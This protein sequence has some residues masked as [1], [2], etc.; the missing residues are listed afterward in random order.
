MGGE[1]GDVV[2]CFLYL[3]LLPK[4]FKTEESTVEAFL[5]VFHSFAHNFQNKPY[6]QSNRDGMSVHLYSHK[7]I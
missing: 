1:T 6:F 5:F 3:Q 7:V 2:Y 4:Y